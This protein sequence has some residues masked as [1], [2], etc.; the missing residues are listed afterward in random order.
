[1]GVGGGAEGYDFERCGEMGRSVSSPESES[2]SSQ[3]SAT[4]DCF[5]W[6]LKAEEDFEGEGLMES[7]LTA[8]SSSVCCQM[9]IFKACQ[10][11]GKGDV[12]L[13]WADMAMVLYDEESGD[14]IR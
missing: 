1:M 11:V 10:I 3:E 14:A 6:D 4:A 13:G 5:F 12:P 9:V 8:D 7:L 2:A